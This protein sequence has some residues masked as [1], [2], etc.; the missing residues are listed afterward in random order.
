MACVVARG[1]CD[2][3]PGEEDAGCG[4]SGRVEVFGGEGGA[5][6]DRRGGRNDEGA[7]CGISVSSVFLHC[8]ANTQPELTRRPP[9][10]EISGRQVLEELDE[11]LSEC[12]GCP[13]GRER[14]GR[15]RRLDARRAQLV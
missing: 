6:E 4:A 11:R 8:S 7:V 1:E 2:D 13:A 5:E 15:C 10:L 9:H 14:V 12:E 3:E